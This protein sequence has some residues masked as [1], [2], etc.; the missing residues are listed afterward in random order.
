MSAYLIVS[1]SP[2]AV[3]QICRAYSLYIIKTLCPNQNFS[4]LPAL[5]T[6]RYDSFSTTEFD[7]S[8]PLHISESIQYL[9]FPACLISLS[10]ILPKVIY[11]NL[12]ILQLPNIVICILF[13]I[14]QWMLSLYF[15]LS[16]CEYYN[17]K[18]SYLTGPWRTDCSGT[19]WSRSSNRIHRNRLLTL[20]CDDASQA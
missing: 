11:G 7:F 15:Y 6:R 18:H 3:F 5:A 8:R 19:L 20:I 16:Y 13:F 2:H 10:I 17:G 9:P 4:S 1:C 14:C 12:H